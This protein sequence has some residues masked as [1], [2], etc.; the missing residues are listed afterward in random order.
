MTKEQ[1]VIVHVEKEQEITINGKP[2]ASPSEEQMYYTRYGYKMNNKKIIVHV[3]LDQE[4]LEKID[5]EATRDLRT[6][7]AQVLHILRE[8][9]NKPEFKWENDYLALKNEEE[10]LFKQYGDDWRSS[11]NN[12]LRLLKK[13]IEEKYNFLFKDYIHHPSFKNI[14]SSELFKVLMQKPEEK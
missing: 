8:H 11:V 12:R 4:L 3:E 13:S 1:K 10:S 6:R 7:K 5:R 14:D 2:L 9:F